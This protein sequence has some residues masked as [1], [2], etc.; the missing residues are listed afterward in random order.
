MTTVAVPL[1]VDVAR[2]TPYQLWTWGQKQLGYGNWDEETDGPY[3][4]WAGLEAHKLSKVMTKR[5]VDHWHFVVAVLW[6]KRHRKRIENATWV[7]KFVA[8]AWAEHQSLVRTDVAELIE[9]AIRV[10]SA[11]NRAQTPD[12]VAR[13]T[14]ARG[15]YRLEVLTEWKQSE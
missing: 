5:G 6:C 15:P 10:E 13:L 14:R 2:W 7:L 8:E 4:K 3:Q 11:R 1:P 12:W 9:Q